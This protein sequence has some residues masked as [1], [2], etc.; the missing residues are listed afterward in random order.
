[1]TMPPAI[2]GR[3]VSYLE[4]FLTEL[5]ARMTIRQWSNYRCQLKRPFV[6]WLF[7]SESWVGE[8]NL[9]LAEVLIQRLVKI[10]FPFERLVYS[11][12]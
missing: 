12:M 4:G 7:N 2:K 8:L 11:G 3:I 1:M 9:M 10:P 6:Y 5:T